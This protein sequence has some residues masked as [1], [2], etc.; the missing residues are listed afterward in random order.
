VRWVLTSEDGFPLKWEPTYH[1]KMFM[2]L[3]SVLFLTG[4]N[5]TKPAPEAETSTTV[6]T[7][8]STDI[9][10]TPVAQVNDWCEAGLGGAA[11][12]RAVA[13]SLANAHLGVRLFGPTPDYLSA[14]QVLI[15]ALADGVAVSALE[16]YADGFDD[17]C[18]YSAQTAP[19]Y[20]GDATEADGWL[21]VVPGDTAPSVSDDIEG[22]VLDLRAAPDASWGQMTAAIGAAMATEVSLG[23][24]VVRAFDG[25][26]TQYGA[27]GYT[28][29]LADLP[30][31]VE[32]TG[33][34]D[35]PIVI[36]TPTAL[37]PEA[38]T[39]AAGLRMAQRAALVGADVHT[40]VAEST[41][42]AVGDQGLLW[43][44]STLYLGNA[45]YPDRVPSDVSSFEADF[46]D[47]SLSEV[48]GDAQRALSSA[49][50][51]DQGFLGSSTLTTAEKRAA[52][53]VAHGTLDWFYPYFDVVGHEIDEALD[54]GLAEIEAAPDAERA[55]FQETL[56]RFM[57]VIQDGHGFFS[58]LYLGYPAAGYHLTVQLIDGESIIRYSGHD[59]LQAGDTILAVNGVEA[60]EWYSDAM[61]RNSAASEGYLHSM[62]TGEL[63]E[64]TPELTV[65]HAD[66][67]EE[68]VTAE[69]KS[70]DVKLTPGMGSWRLSGTLD[71]L[72]APELYYLNL[73]PDVEANISSIKN[74]LRTLS[75]EITGLV[76][77]MRNYPAVNHYEVVPFLNRSGSFNSPIFQTPQ[78]VGPVESGF[79]ELQYTIDSE[80][81]AF[82]GPIV[83]IVSNYTVSAA[84]NFSQMFVD[85]SYVT[86][87]GQPS[88]ATNGTITLSWLPGGMYIYFTG[89][90]VLN[91]DR[92]E[93]HGRGIPVD[94][95][96]TP[97]PEELASGADPELLSA[98]EVLSVD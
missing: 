34:V 27:G 37:G 23:R 15:T 42:S 31:T 93:F 45:P 94:V 29:D 1:E 44:Y 12:E 87:V 95:V 56:G 22:M 74:Q 25:F 66:G 70:Y 18:S 24:R 80:P 57:H 14:D 73:H 20:S 49:Y 2:L 85:E 17:V 59:E 88:A 5:D 8:T 36:L 60:E 78:F 3:I 83:L 69:S 33:D 81:D 10:T 98:I 38:A 97:T 72:G 63:A 58:D 76:V 32:A 39:L 64:L 30:L 54:A 62:A 96:V 51:P 13:A 65:R 82:D 53:M 86:V 46:K 89:M 50:N 41:W 7:S 43:R 52:L 55:A 16:S 79:D 40:S 47:L 61:R 6:D 84:E 26:P 35:L 48:A 67:T 28:T 9:D 68:V 75:D 77:D 11:D 71:D 4:C 19:S 90:R 21:W 91:L 92:S